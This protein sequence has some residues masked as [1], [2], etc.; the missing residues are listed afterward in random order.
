MLH[1]AT[2][3]GT[4]KLADVE[5]IASTVVS[6]D[7]DARDFVRAR[8][9]AVYAW[10]GASGFMKLGFD[11]PA[12]VDFLELQADG[13]VLMQDRA[14]H[15]PRPHLGW[16]ISLRRWPWRRVKLEYASQESRGDVDWLEVLST[17]PWP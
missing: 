12:D 2:P 13:F 3:T 7:P 16:H 1:R 17:S 8:G 14:I 11:R 9:G 6:A 10:I 5:E 4:P 15:A